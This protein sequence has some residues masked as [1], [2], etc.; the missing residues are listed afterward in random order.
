MDHHNGSTVN[1][2]TL[3]ATRTPILNDLQAFN[4][5]LKDFV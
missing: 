5:K 2:E 4:E 3:L 1:F